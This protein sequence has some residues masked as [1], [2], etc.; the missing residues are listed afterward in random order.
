ME[1]YRMQTEEITPE[2][3][4][5]RAERALSLFREGILKSIHST[6]V[7][8]GAISSSLKEGG[9]S[10]SRKSPLWDM[11]RTRM[12]EISTATKAKVGEKTS[13][14][15]P[16]FRGERPDRGGGVRRAQNAWQPERD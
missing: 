9:F 13:P 7:L 16:L 12:E 1:A 2:I 11:V 8:D 14:E 3:L 4:D 6:Q 5:E 10:D 15:L